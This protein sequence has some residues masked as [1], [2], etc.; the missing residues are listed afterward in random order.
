MAQTERVAPLVVALVLDW[1]CGEPPARLHPVVW[2]GR[3]LDWLEA[4]APRSATPRLVYGACVALVLPLGWALFAGAVE[5]CVPWPLRGLILKPAFA[6]RALL[7]S[8]HDV[9]SALVHGDVAL[10]RSKLRALVS[11]PTAHLEGALL[12]AAACESLAENMVDSWLA[13]LLAYSLFGLSG[14]YAYRAANTADAMWGYRTRRYELLGKAS[15]RLDD[16]LNYLPARLGA[17]VM[18]CAA[19]PRWHAAVE[20]WR[21]DSGS[22]SS[23]NAGQSMACAAGALGVRLEKKGHY[24]LNAAAQLPDAE[25]I[26]HARGL[27]ARAMWLSA[28]LVVLPLSSLVRRG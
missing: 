24:V 7:E 1:V 15:A 16:L 22:T 20:V 12:A 2:M 3:L 17:I 27:V 14:A 8:A 11:R 18:C 23:P 21:R 5:R 19:G 28:A 13:P 6:G 9:E 25:S 26:A 10:A 4:R